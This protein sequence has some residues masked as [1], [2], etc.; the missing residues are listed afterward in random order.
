MCGIYGIALK[1]TAI[2]VQK[3]VHSNDSLAHRGP[4]GAGLVLFGRQAKLPENQPQTYQVWQK[5]PLTSA[6]NLVLAHRRL[7]IIDVESGQQPMSSQDQAIWVTFNGEIYNYKAL[8]KELEGLGHYFQTDHSDTEVIIYAYKQWGV[9]C[10]QKFNGMFAF[11]ILDKKQNKLFLA[12]DRFGKKPLYYAHSANRFE[13]ASET[14]ALTIDKN[15][16]YEGLNSYLKFG[17]LPNGLSIYQEIEKMPP[18]HA[19]IFDLNSGQ[20]KLWRYWELPAF[21][22]DVHKSEAE[23]VEELEELFVDAVALRMQSDVPL[24]VFLSGGIDSSLIVAAAAKSKVRTVQTFT[25]SF[26]GEAKFDESKYAKQ[27]AAYF[28]TDHQVL[29]VPSQSFDALD[30]LM[31]FMDEPMADSSLMPTFMIA[32]LAK[33]KVQVVL[34]GDGGDEI[35]AGCPVYLRDILRCKKLAKYPKSMWRL[36]AGVGKHLP[37]GVKGRNFLVSMKE[38]PFLNDVWQTPYFDYHLRKLLL[39]EKVEKTL[40]QDLM[41]PE[42]WKLG[43]LGDNKDIADRKSRFDMAYYLPEDLMVK[44]DRASMMN[45]LEL[46]AP[47]LDYRIVEFAFKYVPT[48]VKIRGMNVRWLQKLLVKRMLPANFDDERDQG[49]CVPLD[50]WL[51]KVDDS[52]YKKYLPFNSSL[53]NDKFINSLIRGQRAHRTNASRLFALMMLRPSLSDGNANE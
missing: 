12:R 28:K 4:D 42:L 5:Q 36:L 48:S 16:S 27:I 2:D 25:A 31:K 14:K 29:K 39:A 52:F 44:I 49:F 3:A 51:R 21:C 11:T 9:D 8:R 46:R 10:L 41:K 22:E 13:F 37:A 26:P 40:A 19:G 24:G 23:L 6:F 17:Y 20:W 47:W 15:V 45:G 38:G 43:V 18:A 1:E 35:F 7:S 50:Q 34:G 53:L 33:E 32:K 30:E